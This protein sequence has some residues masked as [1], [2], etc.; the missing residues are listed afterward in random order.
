MYNQEAFANGMEYVETKKLEGFDMY[1]LGAYPYVVEND[2]G[3]I[4]VDLFQVDDVTKQRIDAMEFGAGYS[5]KE[6]VIDGKPGTIYYFNNTIPD[7]K[8]V[9]DGDWVTYKTHDH[10]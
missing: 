5:A 3:T 9:E 7:T 4:K 8:K 1:S 2:K 10:D 6:V